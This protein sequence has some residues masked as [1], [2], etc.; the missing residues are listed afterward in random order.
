VIRLHPRRGTRIVRVVAWAGG[1]RVGSSHGRRVRV[2]LVGF[3]GRR[4][5]V[6]LVIHDKRHGQPRRR[7]RHVRVRACRAKR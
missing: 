7:T 5:R 1:R 6:R 4:V 3:P 2:K